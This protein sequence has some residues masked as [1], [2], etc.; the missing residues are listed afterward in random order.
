MS[1]S[2]ST[3]PGGVVVVLVGLGVEPGRGEE[4]GQVGGG[5]R[6]GGCAAGAVLGVYEEEGE[7]EGGEEDGGEDDLGVLFLV[8]KLGV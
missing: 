8:G 5:G 7:E 6:V 2:G 4:I 3:A 1:S